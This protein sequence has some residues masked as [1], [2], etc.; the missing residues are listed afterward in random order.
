MEYKIID[1]IKAKASLVILVIDD[2]TG[3]VI[4]DGS[5]QVSI[6][7]AAKPVRKSEGYYVFINLEQS[8]AEL[9]ITS[10]RYTE[11]NISI[12]LDAIT[13][14]EPIVKVRVKPSRNYSLLSGTTFITGYAEPLCE[15]RV[16]CDNMQKYFRLL[17]DYD[18][19]ENNEIIS[20]FNPEN[21]DMDGKLLMIKGKDDDSS[22]TF[23]IKS[24]KDR[25]NNLYQMDKV[26]ENSYKKIGS[27]IY[28]V[29]VTKADTEGEYFI[30]LWNLGNE[31]INCQCELLG[32]KI[33]KQNIMLVTGK[34][35]KL[36]F[37]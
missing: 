30:P 34:M 23:Y 5:I 24:T 27:K 37:T 4:A 31:A 12:D 25:E 20:I 32:S 10:E 36:N 1:H 35:N 2:Y 3:K 22:E 11:E 8:K 16:I 18:P 9:T 13:K 28:P 17:Y 6:A 19:K 29:F 26:L 21:T 14:T 15:I 33:M 7:N